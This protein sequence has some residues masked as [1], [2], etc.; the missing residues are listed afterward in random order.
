MAY[1]RLDRDIA[2]ALSALGRRRPGEGART[3]LPCPGPRPRAERHARRRRL[4]AR[5]VARRDLPLRDRPA[6][7]GQHDQA[8]VTGHRGPQPARRARRRVPRRRASRLPH[9]SL[10]RRFP[11]RWPKA[12]TGA[13]RCGRDDRGRVSDTSATRRL[14]PARAEWHDVLDDY[15]TTLEAQRVYLD[16]VASGATDAEP[17]APFA[18]PTGLPPSPD[19]RSRRDR[20]PA[21]RD[22]ELFSPSTRTSPTGSNAPRVGSAIARRSTST[23]ASVLDRAL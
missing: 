18:V 16:A 23:T 19:D 8:R 22:A 12:P 10:P 5:A 4:G 9:R 13:C 15:A 17:P 21:R 1:D 7:R 2:G 3:A 6:D 11:R 14:R 20:E